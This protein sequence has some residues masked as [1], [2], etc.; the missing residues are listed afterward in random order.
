MLS[1][2]TK[3]SLF[4]TKLI[5]PD[6]SI[7]AFNLFKTY[8]AIT[9]GEQSQTESNKVLLAAKIPDWQLGNTSGDRF[10]RIIVF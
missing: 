7:G 9:W 2:Q 10:I 4:E 5:H 6:T 8:L 1:P 3:G